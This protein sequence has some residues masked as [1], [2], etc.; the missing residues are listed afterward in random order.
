MW[1]Q[2]S[3]TIEYGLLPGMGTRS[4]ISLGAVIKVEES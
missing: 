1:R 2:S 4:A 3:N